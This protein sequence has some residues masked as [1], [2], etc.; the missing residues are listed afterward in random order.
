MFT[1][2]SPAP[3]GCGHTVGTQELLARRACM[4]E[5]WL[6]GRWAGPWTTWLR[7]EEGEDLSGVLARDGEGGG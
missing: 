5:I 4:N 1:E 7:Q 3:R 2:V 6:R